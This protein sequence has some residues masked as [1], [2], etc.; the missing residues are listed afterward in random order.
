MA[1]Y[2]GDTGLRLLDPERLCQQPINA[3]NT[4]DPQFRT[5]DTTQLGPLILRVF[6]Q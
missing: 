1:P 6:R 5:T 4:G 3:A 2:A